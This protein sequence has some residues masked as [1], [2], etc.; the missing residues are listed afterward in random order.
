[1]SPVAGALGGAAA[2]AFSAS[3]RAFPRLAALLMQPREIVEGYRIIRPLRQDA[4]LLGGCRVVFLLQ[5]IDIGQ[6]SPDREIVR[7]LVS[8]RGKERLGFA[9]IASYDVQARQPDRDRRIIRVCRRR[10][11]QQSDRFRLLPIPRVQ[12]RGGQIVYRAVRI[13]L[14]KCPRLG[15]AGLEPA[16]LG[17]E[18][19]QLLLEPS[20]VGFFVKPRLHRRPGFL[21]PFRGDQGAEIALEQRLG[22]RGGLVSLS[23]RVNRRIPLAGSH[24]NT[25][26][27]V[28]DRAIARETC[29]Q[30]AGERLGARPILTS[31]IEIHQLDTRRR[32]VRG[33]IACFFGKPDS[34]VPFLFACRNVGKREQRRGSSGLRDRKSS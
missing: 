27:H 10:F 32:I 30:F 20:I 24:Q 13:F 15:N 19:D 31:A 4:R 12:I 33:C 22:I 3:S 29:R 11:F 7:M 14:R 1:M 6:P 28:R 18:P 25:P 16:G 8:P 23:E 2:I 21:E 9:V 26:L 34:L 17:R 5:Q